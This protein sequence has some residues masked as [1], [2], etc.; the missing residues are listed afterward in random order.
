VPIVT[1]GGAAAGGIVGSTV[2]HLGAGA[3]S[4]AP[5]LGSGALIG[6][7][8]ESLEEANRAG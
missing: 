5:G 1:V 8:I 4:E 2:G 6:D 3:A 7:Q